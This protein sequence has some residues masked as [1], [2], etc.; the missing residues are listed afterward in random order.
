[1]EKEEFKWHS[2]LQSL[3][4]AI[5]PL[6]FKWLGWMFAT[7]GVAYLAERTG[8]EYLKGIETISYTLLMLYF[9]CF[10][11]D[12]KIKPYTTWVRN[13]KNGPKKLLAALPA[14]ILGFILTVASQGLITEVIKQIKLA[15]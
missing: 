5:T 6:W 10:C 9:M 11:M 8:N 7:G 4:E 1:M 12:I 3:I 15:G 14:L 2:S 13:M